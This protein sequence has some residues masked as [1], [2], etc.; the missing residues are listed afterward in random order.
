MTAARETNGQFVKGVSGNPKGRP[1]KKKEEKFMEIS[2]SAVSLKDWREIIKKAADQAKR[3]DAQARRFLADYLLG[4]P[5]QR[6]DVT[7][8]GNP[9]VL[10]NWDD[11]ENSPD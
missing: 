3:G 4:P 10:V 8:G 11:V 2:I 1:P 6:L 7:S 9:F 5:Q